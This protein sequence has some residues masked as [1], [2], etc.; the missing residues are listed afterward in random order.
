VIPPIA[1]IA[2]LID[3]QTTT[4]LVP[5]AQATVLVVPV[6]FRKNIA[7]AIRGFR[8]ER[9]NPAE[10]DPEPVSHAEDR[11]PDAEQPPGGVHP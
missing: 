7:S 10:P 2:C 5:I 1:C 11:A 4:M 3:P 8:G 6:L 9:F